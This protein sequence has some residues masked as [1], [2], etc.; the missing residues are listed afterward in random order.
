MSLQPETHWA[1]Q[2]EQVAPYR[3]SGIVQ[4]V[5][6]HEAMLYDQASGR[7]HRMNETALLVWQA[8]DGRS[9]TREVAQGITE[10]Y[11]TSLETALEDVEQSIAVFAEAGLVTETDNRR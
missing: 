4:Q 5:L 11:D 1:R 3:R 6:D 9:T 7:T 8:C 10:K 2:L